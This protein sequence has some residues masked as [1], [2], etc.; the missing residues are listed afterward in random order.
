MTERSIET[1]FPMT[2]LQEGMLYHTLR[3]PT[4]PVYRGQCTATLRGPLDETVFR[5]AWSALAARHQAFRSFFAWEGRDRPLQV[6]WDGVDLPWRMLDWSEVDGDDQEVRWAALLA[7][8]EA[9]PFELTVAPLMRFTLVRLGEER[10]RL[11]W[12][13]HHALADGWSGLLVFREMLEE[14]EARLSRSRLEVEAPPSYARF[15]TWLGSRDADAAAGHWTRRL[16]GVEEATPP[17]G[18]STSEES[19]RRATIQLTLPTEAMSQLQAAATRMRVTPSTIAVA[20]WAIV[21]A[22]FNPEA[23]E[24]LFGVTVSE[25]PPAIPGVERSVGLYLNTLPVR[26]NVNPGTP[27]REWLAALQERLAEDREYSAGGL[28]DIARWVEAVGGGPLARTLV[29]YESFPPDATRAPDDGALRLED[30]H[31]SAPSDLPVALLVYPDSDLVLQLVYD[32]ALYTPERAKTLIEYAA[33]VLQQLSGEHATVGEVGAIPEA[34]EKLLA[35]WG[36]NPVA[37][38]EPADVLTLFEREVERGPDRPAVEAGGSRWSY[39]ELW[40]EARRVSAILAAEDLPKGAIIGIP[41]HRTAETLAAILGVLHRGLAYSLFDPGQPDGRIE[42]V[43]AATTRVLDR[44]DASRWGDRLV[45]VDGER[46]DSADTESHPSWSPS[47]AAYVVWTS[48]TT[49]KPKGVVVERGNLAC[50]TAAR[51]AHYGHTPERFLLLSP[52]SVDSSVAGLYWTL[53]SGGCLMLTPKGAEQDVETV[54]AGA[55]EGSTTTL[56]VPSLYA[57]LL[58]E[59][60]PIRLRALSRVIVAGEACTPG[61]VQ[62]HRDA[63]PGVELHNEY[64]PSEG[65]VWATVADLLE[66]PAGQASI[67]RPVPH[68]RVHLLDTTGSPVPIGAPGE[69]HLGGDMVARGYLDDPDLTAERFVPDPTLPGGRLYRTGDRGRYLPDGRLDFLG[70]YDEQIKIRGYRVEVG[71]IE[72]TLESHPAVSTAAVTYAPASPPEDVDALTSALLALSE[73]EAD[74]MLRLAEDVA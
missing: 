4:S 51:I 72:R 65:T 60:D 44:K 17:P 68:A 48:G 47:D 28:A 54:L 8:D 27:V 63:L 24:V 26:T 45:A 61:L 50:S 7:D 40:E 64:G 5:D 69:I 15:V 12:S 41:A 73:E 33:S 74:R 19:T 59:V 62:R 46:I 20:T 70:R 16:S 3:F 10:H 57:T 32:E 39:A 6:V 18:A 29:V 9:V 55:A 1:A 34:D 37:L 11:L 42:S 67:G 43:L 58:D 2:P 22:R 71:E 21:N 36:R 23:S 35:E 25:R 56:L 66:E 38:G 14:Y 53:C 31:I 30:T 49:G 52:L 13:L